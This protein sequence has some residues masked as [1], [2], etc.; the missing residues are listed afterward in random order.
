VCYDLPAHEPQDLGRNW[1]LM[2]RINQKGIRPQDQPIPLTELT[3][4]EQSLI[5]RHY[6]EI[7]V[8]DANAK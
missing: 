6:P 2:K 1:S 3:S 7:F 5:L 4:E 8:S